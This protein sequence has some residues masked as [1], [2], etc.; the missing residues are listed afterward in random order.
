MGHCM[1]KSWKEIVNHIDEWCKLLLILMYVGIN[2]YQ[3]VSM[4]IKKENA[5]HMDA[6]Y[7]VNWD[8]WLMKPKWK[9]TL[10]GVEITNLTPRL[11]G[12]W[13]NH[14]DWLRVDV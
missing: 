10:K 5:T 3:K 11:R 4:H 2:A 9:L 8:V 6:C 13:R 1:S 12:I 7:K 14:W